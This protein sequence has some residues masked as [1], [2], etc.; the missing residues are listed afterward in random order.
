MVKPEIFGQRPV[1]T[2]KTALQSLPPTDDLPDATGTRIAGI[3]GEDLL[4]CRPMRLAH[5]KQQLVIITA[6]QRCYP[7]GRLVAARA[8]TRTQRHASNFQLHHGVTS[9]RQSQQI[10]Q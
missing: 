9:L 6:S 7:V 4:E 10:A 2:V 1:L 8:A 3:C 5:R